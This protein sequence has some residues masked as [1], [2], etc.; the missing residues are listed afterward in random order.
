MRMRL[1]AIG[2]GMVFMIGLATIGLT[3][4]TDSPSSKSLALWPGKPPGETGAIDDEVT[5]TKGSP[6]V[7]TSITNVSKPTLT[8]FRPE[9]DK[10]T[11][12]A[13]VVCPGGGYSN[14][15][16]D[17]EG[18]QV[19]RWLKSIGVT[20]AVL[21]YRVPRRPDTPKTEK[22]IQ[23]LMDAQ[24]ALGL[25][26]SNAN[27]WGID[28]SKIGILGFSA[29]GHLGAWA[30]TNYD[31]RSYEAVDAAD[32]VDCRP[33]FAV[34]VYPGGVLK[35]DSD[36]LSPEIRI[37]SQTPPTL[38]V[39][40]TNDRLATSAVRLF[41]ALKDAKVPVE[42]HLYETGGHGFGMRPS[43]ETYGTWTQRCEDWLRARK[44]LKASK[45]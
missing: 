1:T 39:C 11:G 38:L 45:D 30:S 34:L 24:R 8:L 28:P 7:I 27:D 40:A 5:K 44:V 10:N 18:E 19:G 33:D 32:K 2:L 3:A 35:P 43:T 6:A 21:K 13:I 12:V 41:L 31:K 42:C 9:R 25:V 37:T 20:A 4:D 29:G 14:L 26:R 36:E 23:A 16:W 17:H 22:P 15:A